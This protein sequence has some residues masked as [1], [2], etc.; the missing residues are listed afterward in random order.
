M[1]R[2]HVVD[3]RTVP[4]ERPVSPERLLA[5]EML[6]VAA[7]VESVIVST[8]DGPYPLPRPI[9]SRVHDIAREA[10]LI[11]AEMY[12]EAERLSGKSA[13]A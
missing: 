13:R 8:A 6:D 11:A 5:A 2:L 10:R 4:E 9:I 7:F 1:P 3:P 12:A